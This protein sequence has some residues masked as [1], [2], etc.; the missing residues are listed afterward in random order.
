MRNSGRILIV[1]VFLLITAMLF[2]RNPKRKP[3]GDV[4]YRSNC[5]RCHS[6]WPALTERRVGTAVRHMRVRANLSDE[7]AVAIAAY[8]QGREVGK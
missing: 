4:L 6:E 3:E 5:T 8:L 7:E 1:V 2:G